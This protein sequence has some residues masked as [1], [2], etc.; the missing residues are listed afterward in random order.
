SRGGHGITCQ[1][2]GVPVPNSN[3]ATVGSQFDPK[4]VDYLE[5]MRGG[6]A[7]NY[8]DRSCGLF[9]VV[10]STGFEGQRFGEFLATYGN[11]HQTNEYLNFGS[12]TNRLAY[13][14]SLAG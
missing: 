2:D 9:N 13:Y 8:G 11:Y 7:A 5:T 1:I 10:H 3:L 4:D 14:G 6:L 12:H